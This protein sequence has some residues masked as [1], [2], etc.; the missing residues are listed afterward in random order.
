[1]SRGYF[2]RVLDFFL[3]TARRRTSRR[4]IYRLSSG[5]LPVS[6][7]VKDHNANMRFATQAAADRH[8]A[9]PH[10]LS[11]IVAMSVSAGEY[12][13]LFKRGGSQIADLRALPGIKATRLRVR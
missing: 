3:D 11:R 1:M 12:R 10:D 7:A 8:R 13:R 9:H 2:T 6:D 5:G 4:T